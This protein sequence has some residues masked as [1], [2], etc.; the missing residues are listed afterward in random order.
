MQVSEH[1]SHVWTATP[2]RHAM[3]ILVIED[4]REAASWLVKGLAEAGHIADHAADGEEGLGLALEAVHDVLIVD[5]ML[6]KIECAKCRKAF[7][8]QWASAADDLALPRGPALS[9]R[10]EAGRNFSNKLWNATRFVLMNLE[11][12]VAG[13]LAG[14]DVT[15]APTFADAQAAICWSS[16]VQSKLKTDINMKTMIGRGSGETIQVGFEGQGWVLVQPSE[17]RV[18]AMPASGGGGL[19]GVLG[20]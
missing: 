15:S 19:S 2:G 13:P 1:D 8:T 6:P 17:G 5:R 7:R 14:L 12:F 9:E 20:G 18:M 4:D 3:R 11:G 16:G 10:F